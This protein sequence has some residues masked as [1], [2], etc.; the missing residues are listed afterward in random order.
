MAVVYFILG[1]ILQLLLHQHR[2][3]VLTMKKWRTK[4]MWMEILVSFIGLATQLSYQILCKN[5]NTIS[6]IAYSTLKS[7]FNSMGHFVRNLFPMFFNW[8]ILHLWCMFGGS[9]WLWIKSNLFRL[10]EGQTHFSTSWHAT[11]S[12]TTNDW[13]TMI[14]VKIFT[15]PPSIHPKFTEHGRCCMQNN[16]PLTKSHVELEENSNDP[17]FIF[18]ATKVLCPILI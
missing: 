10:I 9:V 5:V 8:L 4:V 7:F 16:E 17:N 2:R 15:Q 1:A 14:F 11:V 13:Y 6:W 12:L 18:T 3:R